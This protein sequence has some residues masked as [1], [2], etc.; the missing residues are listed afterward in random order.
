MPS[1]AEEHDYC[2]RV[3]ENKGKVTFVNLLFCLFYE[4]PEENQAEC[5]NHNRAVDR[6]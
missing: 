3:K 1:K 4:Q 2:E 5:L 6:D